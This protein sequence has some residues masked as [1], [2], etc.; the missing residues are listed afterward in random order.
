M[1]MRDDDGVNW[2]DGH[3]SREEYMDSR[4]IVKVEPR[5]LRIRVRG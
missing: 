2:G 5:D 4:Y 3:G 1:Q